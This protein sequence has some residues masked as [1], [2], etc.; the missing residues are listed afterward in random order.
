M[1]I[2]D[3]C[4]KCMYD[5]QQNKTNNKEYL[6]EIK[7]LLDNRGENE[8]A[9][10]MVYLFNQVHMRYFGKGADYKDIKKEY[11]DLVLGMENTL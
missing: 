6:A 10:H 1:R 3:S 7:A 5:R 11:N 2:S 4:A 9:P 8:T